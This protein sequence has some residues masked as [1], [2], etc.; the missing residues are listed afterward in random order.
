MGFIRSSSRSISERQREEEDEGARIFGRDGQHGQSE[1]AFAFCK[2]I[3]STYESGERSG[4]WIKHRAN[5]LK[6]VFGGKK[7]VTMFEMTKHI[8]RHI[9]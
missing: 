6:A 1:V 8:S 4:A 5:A 7:Q 2:R 3:A 9:K